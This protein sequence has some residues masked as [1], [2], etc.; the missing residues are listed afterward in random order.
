[1]YYC[2][3]DSRCAY[4]SVVLLLRI[5]ILTDTLASIFFSVILLVVSFILLITVTNPFRT[6]VPFWGQVTQIL[7]TRCVFIIANRDRSVEP[8]SDGAQKKRFDVSSMS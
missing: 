6:A 4:V 8:A 7:S 3:S 1:M 2:V 5:L